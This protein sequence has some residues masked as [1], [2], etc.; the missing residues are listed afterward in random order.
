MREAQALDRDLD[1][2]I[3]LELV[4]IPRLLE[5]LAAMPDDAYLAG[6]LHRCRDEAAGL[7]ERVGRASTHVKRDT[8]FAG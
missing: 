1:R 8:A 3:E 2:L 4:E 5:S 7:S 6:E